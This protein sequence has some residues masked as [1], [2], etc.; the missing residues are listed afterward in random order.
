METRLNYDMYIPTHVLFGIG[1]LNKLN[2]QPMPGKHALIVI[3][4]GKS[5]R[6]NGYLAR[7][8]EQLRQAGVETSVFDGVS[9]NPT[10]SNVNAG[11]KAARE[12]GCDFLIAMMNML[13]MLISD[14]YEIHV[15][16]FLFSE[17]GEP[18]AQVFLE[19]HT[20]GTG[21]VAEVGTGIEFHQVLSH[22]DL[23]LSLVVV[24]AEAT[25][26]TVV[27]ESL[28]PWR[29]NAFGIIVSTSLGLLD[30]FDELSHALGK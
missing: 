22:H 11:A 30:E 2:E 13:G 1:M 7:T 5:T 3:S 17:H 12:H 4:N 21:R 29:G 23:L 25:R 20:V 28:L 10:V 14:C 9:P 24:G 6:A 27:P 18:L 16:Q 8:E 15:L 26:G 19:K